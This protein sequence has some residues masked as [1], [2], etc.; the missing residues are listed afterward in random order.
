MLQSVYIFNGQN[1]TNP[2]EP[3]ISIVNFNIRSIKATF[4]KFNDFLSSC[5]TKFNVI[6]LTESWMDGD[7]C[8][9]DFTITPTTST[10]CS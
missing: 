7:S 5:D 6:T 9:D 10:S 4:S 1:N 8:P 3:E 2:N